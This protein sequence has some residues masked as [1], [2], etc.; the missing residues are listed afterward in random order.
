MLF[1]VGL[2]KAQREEKA[3]LSPWQEAL[4]KED[5]HQSIFVCK[6]EARGSS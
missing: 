1:Y 3:E 4:R 5:A 6:S 2:T